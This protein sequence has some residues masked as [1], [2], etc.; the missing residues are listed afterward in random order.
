VP[1]GGAGGAGGNAGGVAVD[2]N[3]AA[4][5]NFGSSNVT[6][7][8]RSGDA[9][10][11]IQLIATASKPVSVAFGQGHLVVL[12][13][14][15]VESFRT[16][17]LKVALQSDGIVPL[18]I[19]DGSAAQVVVYN[20]GAMYTEKTGDIVGVPFAPSGG[21]A[22]P[23]TPVALPSAPN[24]NTPF[25]IVAR[26]NEVYVTIAHSNLEALVVNGQIVSLAEGTLPYLNQNGGFLH[27]PCWNTLFEQFLF[28]SDSP[29][30]RLSRY[31]VSDTNIFFDKPQVA[32]LNGAPTDLTVQNS[33]LGVIDG[34]SGG[35]SDISLF[36]LTT[37]GEL[38]L[39]FSLQIAGPIN[40]VGIVL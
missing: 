32:T 14:T 30:G 20:G 33:L 19:G 16:D 24:N 12:G 10:A 23:G 5:V 1:T 37:E 38:N 11:P 29:G 40:G 39:E 34:G 9:M 8:S 4:V 36:N 7:F 17:G 35:I 26:N 3:L 22:G 21:L 13:Q 31:L 15:T 2:G 28:A 25:G 27:A 6:I 18:L